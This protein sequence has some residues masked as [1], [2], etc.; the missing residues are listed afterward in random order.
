M[1][2]LNRL[3]GF[4]LIFCLPLAKGFDIHAQAQ[5][6][7]R[8]DSVGL[9]YAASLTAH[10]GKGDFA[11]YYIASNR[12]GTITQQAGAQLRFAAWK[13][14][15]RDKRFSWSAGADFIS[16][17]STYTDYQR[18]DVSS[19]QMETNR[20]RPSSIWL[21]QLYAELKWRQV[22]LMVGMKEQESALFNNPLG[23]GDYVE[24]GNARPIPGLRI[25]FID[26]QNIPFT[27][28][29]L[30]IQ[31]EIAYGRS[32]DKDW[33]KNHYN[34]YN[35][36]V[37]ADT[38]YHYKRLY[39]R[40]SPEQNLS[41]TFGMQAAAQFKGD[42]YYYKKGQMTS[43]KQQKFQLRDLWDMLITK[44]EDTYYK[45]NHLGAWDMKAVYRLR[46]GSKIAAYFQWP[47]DDGS[48]IGKLN[49]FD[50]IWGLEWEQSEKGLLSG[51]VIEFL[52]FMNQSGP[53]HLDP[54][55]SPGSNMPIHTD[56]SDNYYNNYQYNG[57]AH[58][59]MGIGSPFFPSTLYNLDGYMQYVDNRIR[60]FHTGIS[61]SLS[62]CLDY[63]I[64]VSYR[65][66][67]GT[68][69][70][71]RKSPVHDTSA[72]IETTWQVPHLKGLCVNLQVGIDR[73]NL[74]GN[75]Y[76]ALLKV[77]YNGFLTKK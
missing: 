36:F 7:D 70:V 16:G 29:M 50:G 76:G 1:S 56:G 11:P 53:M 14:L 59:G 27:K 74:Y 44:G 17:I 5:Q 42:I 55:D 33:L 9:A 24:S 64:L 30:Q 68:G 63:R 51:A 26:F 31:G 37:T 69:Y 54:E 62:A 25:G 22:F 75:Q 45:G 19:N 52:T 77:M 6:R 57:Y 58:H 15:E 47:W 67:F 66:G 18:Y 32:T 8:T 73:G 23:S 34:Y 46:S 71:P 21:Q 48:G 10:A 61:G 65:E 35:Y 39:F 60:G 28:G 20:Q 13:P 40:T 43:S 72:M 12:H 4:I 38:W 49:G 41:V 2:L 3:T